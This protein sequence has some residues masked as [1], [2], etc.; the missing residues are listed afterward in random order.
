MNKGGGMPSLH[1]RQRSVVD[2]DPSFAP[3]VRE[4]NWPGTLMALGI[5]FGLFTLIWLG[6]RTFVPPV[7]I[8]R[9]LALLCVIGTLLPYVWTGLRFGM[10]RFEW[11][12]FNVLF[13][14]PVVTSLLVL[15]NHFVHDP[16]VYV[17]QP[18][19]QNAL[20]VVEDNGATQRLEIG[21]NSFGF[22]EGELAS[23]TSGTYRVGFAKGCFGYWSVVSC[24]VVTDTDYWPRSN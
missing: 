8:F 13:I 16:P 19:R 12:L 4:Q 5:F 15:M 6:S 24:D 7:V 17:V 2:G 10:A 22:T 23:S 11:F 3:V 14:G 18:F 9:F 1:R 20:A 21:W